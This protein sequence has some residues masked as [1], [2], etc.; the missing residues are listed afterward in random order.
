MTNRA[1]SKKE[2]IQM[3]T[4]KIKQE[5]LKRVK[6]TTY[7]DCKSKDIESLINALYKNGKHINSYKLLPHAYEMKF[8]VKD[9]IMSEYYR[10]NIAE[11]KKKMDNGDWNSTV[12]WILC[13]LCYDGIIPEGIYS[14]E[15]SA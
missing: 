13:L 9:N 14:F 15:K 8:I 5:F 4:G 1:D 3:K 12:T 7:F 2:S 10:K 11:V 6:A